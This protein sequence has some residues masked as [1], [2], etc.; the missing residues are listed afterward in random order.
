MFCWVLFVM[1][2]IWIDR[3]AMS[4]AFGGFTCVLGIV[5]LITGSASVGR[6]RKES[7]RV[8]LVLVI[9]GTFFTLLEAYDIFVLRYH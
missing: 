1:A 6:E 2:T 7:R 9:T 8:G 5:I 4:L 3:S